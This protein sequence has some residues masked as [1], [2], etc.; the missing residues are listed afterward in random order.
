VRA[1][2]AAARRVYVIKSGALVQKTPATPIE[3][4]GIGA[5]F[6]RQKV[7]S[8]RFPRRF[9]PMKSYQPPP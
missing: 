6:L 5:S 7:V 9:V 1:R 8:A 3:L 2:R 4:S